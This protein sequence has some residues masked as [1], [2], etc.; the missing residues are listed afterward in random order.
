M[1]FSV[2]LEQ[3]PDTRVAMVVNRTDKEQ[4]FWFSGRPEVFKPSET[5]G[6]LVGI[7]DWLFRRD[8]QRC[9][10]VAEDGCAEIFNGKCRAHGS[11]SQWV[12]RFGISAGPDDLLAML[13]PDAFETSPIVEGKVIEGWE[14]TVADRAGYTMRVGQVQTP[15]SDYVR[16]PNAMGVS[17]GAPA[18]VQRES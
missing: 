1:A 14:V 16:Q 9:W 17:M 12:F 11:P 8:Q 10:T 6:V 4:E 15:R 2:D 7:A 5:R 3:M 13:A 18:G